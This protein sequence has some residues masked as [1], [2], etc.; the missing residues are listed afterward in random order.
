MNVKL[1]E[2]EIFVGTLPVSVLVAEYMAVSE[3]KSK[4]SYR[5]RKLVCD[6]VHYMIEKGELGVEAETV[7]KPNN[8]E[9]VATIKPEN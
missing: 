8:P 5:E 9:D 2:A 4:L 1:N 6:R 3:K 7:E